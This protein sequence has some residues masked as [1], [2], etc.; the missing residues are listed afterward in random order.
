MSDFSGFAPFGLMEFSGA[1]T[2]AETAYD[3]ILDSLRPPA[4]ADSGRIIDT[5]AFDLTAGTEREAKVYAAAMQIGY[6]RASLQAARDNRSPATA[7]AKLPTLEKDWAVT[8]GP[9]DNIDAR[10]AAVK[11]RKLLMCGA[12]QGAIEGDLK[13]LLG[14]DFYTLRVTKHGESLELFVPSDPSTTGSYQR[15]D[16]APKYIKL[17]GPVCDLNV[18]V[19]VAY[20]LLG[21]ST[22]P[23][24]GDVFTFTPADPNRV[25]AVTISGLNAVSGLN[26]ITATFKKPKDNGSCALTCAPW[27]VTTHRRVRVIVSQA[28]AKDR[29]TRRK[30]HEI[31]ARHS[32]TVTD[33][34][35]LGV[36]SSTTVGPFVPGVSTVGVD[37]LGAAAFTF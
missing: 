18:A 16:V 29:E 24:V 3:S 4:D 32:K 37:A 10:Q 7:L 19:T 11:S 2:Y 28:A 13:A 9:K 36:S 26:T 8:P 23:L 27:Q 1:P 20:A 5:P 31:M 6:A 14:S 22:A 15:P 35:I 33:W 12:R 34:E 30:I 25:E 17:L 21:T